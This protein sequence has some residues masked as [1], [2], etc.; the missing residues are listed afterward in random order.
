MI[1]FA[2][3]TRF[4]FL[5]CGLLVLASPSRLLAEEEETRAVWIESQTDKVSAQCLH[6]GGNVDEDQKRTTIGIGEVVFLTLNGKNLDQN[7]E[8]TWEV[9]GEGAT[10]T[11][12][13]TT[14]VL[15]ANVVMKN[16]SVTVTAETDQGK[17]TLTFDIV[18]P[19]G[20]TGEKRAPIQIPSGQA[21]AGGEIVVTVQ[22]ISVSFINLAVTERD[23]GTVFE[24][25]SDMQWEIPPHQPAP[26][27]VPI[28]G[29]NR[30]TDKV[31]LL[32]LHDATQLA[33]L[34]GTVGWRYVC[35]SHINH[36]EPRFEQVNQVF[37]VIRKKGI[38]PPMNNTI[39][40][41]TVSVTKFGINFVNTVTTD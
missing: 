17:G 38:E 23:R 22:P 19:S 31:A 18:C 24:S 29:Y 26:H 13:N 33:K 25:T 32:M 28:N 14:A 7:T 20:L 6:E 11:G 16:S 5:L 15:T 35:D 40:T 41:V 2:D 37:R 39:H 27:P 34:E 36:L 12:K 1:R 9:E 3:T 21:G 10:I 30:F 8:V 4:V